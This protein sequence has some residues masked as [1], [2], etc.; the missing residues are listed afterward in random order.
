MIVLSRSPSNTAFVLNDGR[1]SVR[2]ETLNGREYLVAPVVAI[3]EGVL[4]GQFV[5]A[6]EIGKQFEA[7]NG[8]PI[9]IN[10]PRLNGEYVS[11]RSS[12]YLG[13]EVGRFDNVQFDGN[14]LKGYIWLDVEKIKQ[15]GGEA[16]VALERLQRGLPVEVSTGYWVESTKESGVFRG[17]EYSAVQS[18]II[19][20]HLALLPNGTGACSWEDGCGTPRVN[21]KES[22]V[23]SNTEK[24][25][26]EKL[27]NTFK[28]LAEILG[29]RIQEKEP[30]IPVTVSLFSQKDETNED[31]FVTNGANLSA[32]LNKMIKDQIEAERPKR[33]IIQQLADMA[34]IS[35]DK[36]QQVLS[37]DV[38]FIPFRW[39]SGFASALN[40]D[41]WELLQAANMDGKEFMIKNLPGFE[42]IFANKESGEDR[43]DEV[44]NEEPIVNEEVVEETE[45]IIAEPVA[46]ELRV[47]ECECPNR[48]AERAAEEL[49]VEEPELEANSEVGEVVEAVAEEPV[50]NE[51]REPETLEE[52]IA[53]LPAP[54]KK[55]IQEALN[56]L[57]EVRQSLVDSIKSNS[58]FTEEDLVDYCVPKLQKLNNN[59]R[60][61]AEA[62]FGGRPLPR[63]HDRT[64]DIPS[65]PPVLLQ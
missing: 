52:A 42:A 43:E 48:V 25:M 19:P 58:D 39:L 54:F 10:H 13:E 34:G 16:L 26:N 41:S 5:P 57:N 20:D 30:E 47:E 18:R 37:G 53:I 36:V 11:A 44:N 45:E 50:V 56:V 24:T 1:V 28:S 9:T 63:M 59:L 51:T 46:N 64:D 14:S 35:K 17:Q 3:R 33:T 49:V 6:E 8:V 55:Q 29:F 22:K 23:D 4:N 27:L 60:K 65:P 62:D 38:S 12:E 31:S 2:T 40:V 15:L 61:N 32:L 21:D 7:W